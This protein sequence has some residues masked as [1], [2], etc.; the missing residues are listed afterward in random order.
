VNTVDRTDPSMRETVT[1]DRI[2]QAH[3]SEAIVDTGRTQPV[4]QTIRTEPVHDTI[5]TSPVTLAS[6][7][8]DPRVR[9]T[10]RLIASDKVEGTAVRNSAGDK[11]GTIERVMID[12]RSGKI[13][14][15]VMTFGGFL[16]IGQDYVTLPWHVLRYSEDLD[17]YELNV[18]ADQLRGAPR[19]AGTWDNDISRDWERDIHSYYGVD[20]YW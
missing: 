1:S 3:T 17:A 12:K 15:A 16:G 8:A 9:E 20:P 4:H 18:T 5:R 14:Y 13:A 11:V 2:G 19:F 7:H 6:E 10:A